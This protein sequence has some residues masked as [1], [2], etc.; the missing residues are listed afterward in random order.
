MM[1]WRAG[2][3]SPSIP[4]SS[5]AHPPQPA[6]EEEEAA[7]ATS[8]QRTLYLVNIF[9]GN[10]A[11]FLNNFADVCQDKLANVHRRILRL[12]ASLTLLEAKLR[13]TCPKQE[14][15]DDSGFKTMGSILSNLLPLDNSLYSPRVS[16]ESLRASTDVQQISSA[17]SFSE[18]SQSQTSSE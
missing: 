11:R 8:D 3:R 9:I 10:T 2:G 13:S 14:F 16:S 5:S 17:L 6:D 7:F 18:R 4:P 1:P 12:D 15:E